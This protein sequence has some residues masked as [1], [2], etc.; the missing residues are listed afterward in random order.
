MNQRI[1]EIAF[2]I[3]SGKLKADPGNAK[4]LISAYKKIGRQTE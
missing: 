3:E 2:E 4:D 1:V